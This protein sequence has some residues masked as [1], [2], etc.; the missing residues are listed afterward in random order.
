[1]TLSELF[2]YVDEI[3]PNAFS[4]E[5]KTVWLNELEAR[6]QR[7]VLLRWPGGMVRY[8]WPEDAGASPLLDAPDDAVYRHWLEA[9]ID[10]ANGEYDKYQSTSAIFNR[11][12]D[13]FVCRFATAWR[14][15]DG[16]RK[17]EADR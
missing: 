8:R 16:Y 10:Y 11:M 17:R 12:W 13:E 7:D 4:N 1:M 5:R 15:A 3:K 9:M 6:I 2:G 14:P